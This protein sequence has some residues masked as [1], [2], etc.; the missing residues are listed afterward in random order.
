MLVYTPRQIFLTLLAVALLL[1]V[2]SVTVHIITYWPGN[3]YTYPHGPVFPMHNRFEAWLSL[4]FDRSLPAWYTAILY[5]A[6]A[7]VCLMISPRIWQRMNGQ[8]I[9]W[10]LL[11]G[12]CLL[13]SINKITKWHTHILPGLYENLTVWTIAVISILTL[14][15][16]FLYVVPKQIRRLLILC[17]SLWIGTVG[18][19]KL[20]EIFAGA[21]S[22]NHMTAAL[23]G[24]M[25]GF[26][27]MMGAVVLIYAAAN[28]LKMNKNGPA[29]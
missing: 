23:L 13:I 28:Y 8:A 26:T 27:E 12:G 14:C 4:D 5:G 15:G 11:G 22:E 25:E 29:G 19:D 21:Y 20:S 18:M 24:D 1:T 6:G 17:G 9:A 3:P 10:I 7:C 16:Y 2:I